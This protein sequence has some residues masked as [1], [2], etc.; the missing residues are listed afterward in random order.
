MAFIE[1]HQ[2][3]EEEGGEHTKIG[4]PTIATVWSRLRRPRRGAASSKHKEKQT[5]LYG[6]GKRDLGGKICG[7]PLVVASTG[8]F[9]LGDTLNWILSLQSE[10]S[11]NG[12]L[13]NSRYNP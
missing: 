12:G 10:G 6:R 5:V 3:G 4:E 7:S 2:F 11:P 8:V 1:M 9:S 13:L